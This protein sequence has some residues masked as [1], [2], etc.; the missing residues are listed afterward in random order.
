MTARRNDGWLGG[1]LLALALPALAIA[2]TGRAAS[3]GGES[4]WLRTCD[5]DLECGEI[6]ACQCGVCTS[7][8]DTTADCGDLSHA[9]CAGRE[10]SAASAQCASESSATSI[11]LPA[12][13]D[14]RPCPDHQLCVDGAC[15]RTTA[16]EGIVSPVASEAGG[17]NPSGSCTA[18]GDGSRLFDHY[19]G[20]DSTYLPDCQLTLPREYYRV[21]TVPDGTAYMIPRP[22]GNPDLYDPCADPNHE[23]A[24]IV[25]RYELCGFAS[26]SSDDPEE[27]SVILANAMDPADAL[28]VAHY[29]HERLVFRPA[30]GQGVNPGVFGSDIL[31]ACKMDEAFR[32]GVLAE[33]CDFEILAEQSG[34]RMPI[35]FFY[36]GEQA[37]VLADKMNELYGIAGDEMCTRLTGSA[38]RDVESRVDAANQCT[39]DDDCRVATP[40]TDCYCACQLVVS[41]AAE[42]EL[43]SA[44]GDIG[45]SQC[46]QYSRS[47][48]FTVGACDCVPGDQQVAV[49]EDG[50]CVLP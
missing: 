48:C 12:C 34:G 9:T 26:S 37:R 30:A 3:V 8:C 13:S 24:A 25:A 20:P 7:P 40:D 47:S 39:S 16:T 23:L 27:E 14:D 29:L 17:G 19:P 50:R 35:G 42:E 38:T 2:C 22:D 6:G 28:A 31:D 49:C 1:L 15:T 32:N 5:A 10:S 46:D 21:F 18:M 36:E 41:A 4:N 33:R 11:C 43:T 45:A 44:L